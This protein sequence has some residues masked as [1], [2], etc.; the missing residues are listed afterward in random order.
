MSPQPGDEVGRREEDGLEHVE[1]ADLGQVGG[2]QGSAP[3]PSETPGLP[4]GLL[5]DGNKT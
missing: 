2:V 4:R 1:H 5:R 3:R